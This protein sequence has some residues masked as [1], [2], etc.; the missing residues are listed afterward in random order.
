MNLGGIQFPT[1]LPYG[2][3]T[4]EI[5]VSGCNKD[6][7]GCHNPSLQSFSYGKPLNEEELI[8]YL[9]ERE[10]LFEIISITGGDLLD[11]NNIEAEKF[12]EKL[13]E[14]I[15]GKDFWLF[16]GNTLEDIQKGYKI[17]DENKNSSHILFPWQW[18]LDTFDVIKVGSYNEKEKQEG[19]PA[20]KNQKVLIRGKDY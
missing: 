7:V 8:K 13:K 11:Q 1:F 18:V 17:F 12:I 10:D 19:F 6:C 20:S 14:E 2:K 16:T 4:V 5:Y 15:R 9:K 3:A